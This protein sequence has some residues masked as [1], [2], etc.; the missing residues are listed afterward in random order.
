[1][2]IARRKRV[3][4]REGNYRVQR[5]ELVEE[6]S[7]RREKMKKERERE[8]GWGTGEKRERQGRVE[9][10][11]KKGSEGKRRKTNK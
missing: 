10:E 6:E 4:M 7:G 1:M 9:R 2:G 3:Y 5:R 8:I 11:K